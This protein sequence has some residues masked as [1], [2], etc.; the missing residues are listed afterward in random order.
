MVSH[1]SRKMSELWDLSLV[2]RGQVAWTSSVWSI[3]SHAEAAYGITLELSTL[4][5][6]PSVAALG[7]SH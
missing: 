4:L 5:A 1:T 3:G 7:G 2:A 6:D